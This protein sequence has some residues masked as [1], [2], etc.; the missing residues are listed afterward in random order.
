[1]IH[2]LT[3]LPKQLTVACSG[4][5]DSMCVVDFLRRK[6]EIKLAFFHHGTESSSQALQFLAQWAWENS[7]ELVVDWLDENK[8][9][10][11]SQEEHWRD[12]R[13]QFLHQL[14]G[15]VVTAHHLDDCVETYLF[16]CL[17]G[18]SYTIPLTRNNVTRP[19]LTTPKK[20]FVDWCQRHKVPWVEDS[21]NQDLGYMRNLIRHK[22]VPEALRV[23]PGLP[24]VVKKI[25]LS[26]VAEADAESHSH[27]PV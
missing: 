24:K 2:L 9:K 5:V 10:D 20:T 6:H 1:M 21:S 12:S 27:Q 8:P 25:V 15:V 19:F 11:K 18:K 4:G 22:I 23:N 17:H 3:K 16:N 7:L 26:Q 14:V 13:Y